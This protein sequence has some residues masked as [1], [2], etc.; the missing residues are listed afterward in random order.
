[1]KDL[2]NDMKD[3]FLGVQID[4]EKILEEINKMESILRDRSVATML[5]N[6]RDFYNDRVLGELRYEAFY[7]QI[8]NKAFEIEKKLSEQEKELEY[9]RSN[10]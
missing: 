6:F 2:F 5:E 10:K 9:Y 4:S 8:I 7:T 3:L 1:M